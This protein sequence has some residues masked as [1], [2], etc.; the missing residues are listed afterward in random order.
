MNA[1]KE[2]SVRPCRAELRHRTLIVNRTHLMHA[3]REYESFYNEHR[4][5]RTLRAAAPLPRSPNR[6][7][8]RNN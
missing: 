8:H 2:R 3:L 7:S 4:S 1:N 6:S 5:H